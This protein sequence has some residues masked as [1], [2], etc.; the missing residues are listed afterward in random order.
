MKVKI[1]LFGILFQEKDI[2]LTQNKIPI[3]TCKF[4]KKI[5]E[6]LSY[7]TRS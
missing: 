1:F 3:F 4:F 2:K 6:K 7:V 5:L